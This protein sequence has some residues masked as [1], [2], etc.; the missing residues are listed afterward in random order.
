VFIDL[1]NIVF[2]KIKIQFIIEL[3]CFHPRFFTNW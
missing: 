3:M 2:H 1:N